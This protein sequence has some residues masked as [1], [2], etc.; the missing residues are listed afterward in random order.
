MKCKSLKLETVAF[1]TGHKLG[2]VNMS[3]QSESGDLFGG[4]KPVG[5]RQIVAP[6]KDEYLQLFQKSFSVKNNA[7]FLK[8]IQV[9]DYSK[10]YLV[11]DK[12][13]EYVWQTSL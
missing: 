6:L 4:Y 1:I 10:R 9:S 12:E 13:V 8:H 5:M 2:V 3:Q 7:A 11:A